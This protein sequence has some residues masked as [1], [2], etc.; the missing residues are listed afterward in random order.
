MANKHSSTTCIQFWRS[1][2]A[3]QGKCWQTL[4]RPTKF[5]SE[6]SSL[7]LMIKHEDNLAIGKIELPKIGPIHHCGTNQHSGIPTQASRFHENSPCVSCFIVVTMFQP[8]QGEHTN[9][10]HQLL[11]MVSKNMKLKESYIQGY[12]IVNYNI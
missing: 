10:L 11:L 3:I 2:K 12:H 7:A 1:S 9:H 6:R 4:W 5:Q 8:F